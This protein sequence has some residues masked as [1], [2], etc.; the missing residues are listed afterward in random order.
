MGKLVKPVAM[1]LVAPFGIGF[2]GYANGGTVLADGGKSQ[3][4]TG[5]GTEL[6]VPPAAPSG[7]NDSWNGSYV[8]Y[9]N[10]E[11]SPIR[12]RVLDPQTDI[13]GSDTMF[14]DSEMVLF[15]QKYSDYLN[16]WEDCELRGFLNGSFFNG[17]FSSYEG[18][19]IAESIFTGSAYEEG[20]ILAHEYGSSVSLDG[21]KVFILS[22]ADVLNTSYGYSDD[23]G[24]I[25]PEGGPEVLGWEWHDVSNHIKYY[26]SEACTWWLREANRRDSWGSGEVTSDGTLGVTYSS[27][28]T[29]GVAPAL[30]I[31]LGSV[32][33]S[34]AVS[35]NLNEAGTGYK[36]TISDPEL[37]IAVSSEQ[38]IDISGNTVTIPCEITGADAADVTRTSILILDKEYGSDDNN[39]I[40]YDAMSSDG[41]FELPSGLSFGGWG[42]DYYVYILAEITRG[43]YETDYACD[44]VC[45]PAPD[46]SITVTTD[47]N[48]TASASASD[49]VPGTTVDLTAA[50]STGYRFKEWQV[51]SGGVTVTDNSFVMGVSDVQ[52]KA[53]FEEIPSSDS[54][55]TPV[56]PFDG[57][58][59]PTP[60][61]AAERGVAGF[62]E[63]LY[64]VALG[65][66]SDPVGK[67][68]WIDAI[69]LRGETGAS[70]ARGF[71]YSP[72]FLNKQCSTEEFVTVLYRTFFD[73]EPDRAGFNA[74]VE[75]LNNGTSK[76]EV[77]EGFINSTEWANLCLFYGIRSGGTG[78]PSIEI[79]PNQDTIDFATR[80]YTTCLNREAD[81][82]GLMAWARQLAN[83]RDTGTGAARGFFFSN[84]F[85]GQNVTNE[86][87]VNRLYRTFMGREA[88]EAGFTAWVAQLN[89]GVSREEVF[90]GFA[91]SPEFT[92]ICASYGIVR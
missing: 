18:G 69:T 11:G 56:V 41:A 78:I 85:T 37:S 83:Q 34:T 82:N 91:Q 57:P 4:N 9:G 54:N 29:I 32:I 67:Q 92:R 15:R 17:S 16:V 30:N 24:C 50:P 27:G 88:D 60:S 71:L 89:E 64:T 2:A 45:V 33:F 76:E 70:C 38:R 73:R 62:V 68:D 65:R 40:Y 74:W 35:G 66:R 13:Y 5:L 75:T 19:A 44:P 26:G 79:E 55:E 80:L 6:I 63:R 7:I 21:D 53:V 22:A 31:D 43:Q 87:Y 90:E 20:S 42:S 14:L 51:I 84:E 48:G 25:L 28:S 72:E 59:A 46:F 86:E 36:L 3:D 1:A 81:S 77:I 8:Y 23:F 39:I 58:S 49:A 12:F 47:G 61:P 52:I 10:Y